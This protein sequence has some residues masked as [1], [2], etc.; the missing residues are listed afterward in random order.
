LETKPVAKMILFLQVM[1][2]QTLALTRRSREPL[3]CEGD[4]RFPDGKRFDRRDHFGHAQGP[5]RRQRG[6][7][8]WALRHAPRLSREV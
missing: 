3:A 1:S 6:S 4:R 7:A 8:G 5:P 2:L